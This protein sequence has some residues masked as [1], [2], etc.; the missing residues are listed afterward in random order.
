MGVVKARVEEHII[1][2]LRDTSDELHTEEIAARVGLTRH[3]VSKYLQV[4][5]AK[6]GVHVRQVGNAKLWRLSSSEIHIRPLENDDLPQILEIEKRV[7]RAWNKALPSRP[8]QASKAELEVFTKTVQYHIAYTD[9]QLRLGA[10]FEG[11]LV[12][13]IVGEIRLWEFGVG[14]EVGWINVMIVDPDHQQRG[15]GHRLG[16]QLL[17]HMQQRGIQRVRTLTDSYAGEMIS[18]FRSLGFSIIT[19]LPME[20]QLSENTE[21]PKR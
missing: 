9:P 11:E 3:T 12:G 14:E 19:M 2:V 16:Q 4:M 10:E 17:A 6:G 1:E 15:I 8:A 13:F 18:F 5:H 20:K 21:H 7:Q